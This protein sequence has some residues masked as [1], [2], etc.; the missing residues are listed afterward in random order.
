M[1]VSAVGT[2]QVAA[3]RSKAIFRVTNLGFRVVTGT[4]GIVSGTVSVDADGRPSG[5]RAV[6]DLTSINTGNARRDK[7]LRAPRLL[8]AEHHPELVFRAGTVE[9]TVDGWSVAGY[10]SIGG[11]ETPVILRVTA[12]A[13][14]PGWRVKAAGKLDRRDTRISKVPSLLIGRW[15]E[16]EVDAHLAPAPTA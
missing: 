10:L 13:E 9:S 6:L 5:G 1:T 2:W 15:I 3:A 7:D 16:I 8:D 4:I 11:R 14:G 12:A